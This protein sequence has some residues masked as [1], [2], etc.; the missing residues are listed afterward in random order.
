MLF[1]SKAPEITEREKNLINT[2]LLQLQKTNKI[3]FSVYSAPI[4]SGENVEKNPNAEELEE[5][6]RF[7]RHLAAI[8]MESFGVFQALRFYE[9]FNRK[10][11]TVFVIRGIRSSSYAFH[12][13]ILR[14]TLLDQLA[15][16]LDERLAHYRMELM[17]QL[18]LYYEYAED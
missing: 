4:F 14:S 7:S 18:I 9:S 15:K 5:G 17:S 16:H 12:H 1:R 2:F 8:D 6:R 13:N 3:N 10:E 11:K